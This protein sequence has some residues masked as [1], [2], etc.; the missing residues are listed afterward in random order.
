[1]AREFNASRTSPRIH[2]SA[3]IAEN[4]MII[5]DVT[6]GRDSS[7]WFGSMIRGDLR[8]IVIGDETNIQDSCV[9]HVDE[10]FPCTIGNRV[11]FGHGAIVHGSI[12]G[13]RVVI[14]IRAVVLD[15]CTIGDNTI[16]GAGT[17]LRPGSEI[18][19][20]SL[21]VGVPGRIVRTLTDADQAEIDRLCNE[22]LDRTRYY[23]EHYRTTK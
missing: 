22:Y 21:V 16:I 3:F 4:A 13:D 9:V 1:M 15:G 7:V 23:R 12:L 6:I 2:E 18:P 5:G 17:V 11:T 10:H 8:P 14:G 20:N 19:P